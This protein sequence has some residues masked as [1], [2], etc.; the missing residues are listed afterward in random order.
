MFE[1]YSRLMPICIGFIFGTLGAQ[2]IMVIYYSVQL[3]RY[4]IQDK[5]QKKEEASCTNS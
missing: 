3:I 4:K 1:D 5:R 2:V